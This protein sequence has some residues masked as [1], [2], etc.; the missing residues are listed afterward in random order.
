MCKPQSMTFKRFAARLTENNNLLPL[1]PVLD[2]SKKIE[3]EELKKILLHAVPNGWSKQSY[4]Q[5]C[6]FELNTY[7]KTCAM[8]KR[9]EVSEQVYEGGTPYKIPTRTESNRGVH[10]KKL[11]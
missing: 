3:T 1:L 10:V 11:R 2:A 4:L 7:R 6:Y 5:G 9:M 8:L